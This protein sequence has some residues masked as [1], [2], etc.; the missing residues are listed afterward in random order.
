M[1]RGRSES[2]EDEMVDDGWLWWGLGY[3]EYI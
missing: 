2:T 1:L 3:G